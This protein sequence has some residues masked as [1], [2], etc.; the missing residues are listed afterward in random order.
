M[1]SWRRV[2]ALLSP[3]YTWPFQHDSGDAPLHIA[4]IDPT[5]GNVEAFSILSGGGDFVL[6][7]G[8]CRD[9][10]FLFHPMMMGHHS[11]RFSVRLDDSTRA[12]VIHLF[13]MGEHR[14]LE[15]IS[16]TVDFGGVRVGSTA[17]TTV[18][19]VLRNSGTAPLTI[20]AS[21]LLG[22]DT[23]QFSLLSGGGSFTLAPGA[24]RAARIAFTPAVVGRTSGRVAYAGTGRR[25]VSS[26]PC[27]AS[28]CWI[29][30]PDL[31]R[32]RHST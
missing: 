26:S 32:P 2:P 8:E 23:L 13:G 24:V 3:G 9:I 17:D 10:H 20:D 29:F 27:R 12:D 15:I 21:R 7:P 6:E 22:P 1:L 18:D 30:L 28:R 31:R 5:S 16:R 14:Q 25:P 4:G 19:V 11:A